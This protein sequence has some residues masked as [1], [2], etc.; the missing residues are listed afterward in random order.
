MHIDEILFY[1]PDEELCQEREKLFTEKFEF[2]KEPEDL[3]SSKLYIKNY[4]N[5]STKY[6]I[7]V[8]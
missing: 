2:L 1:S 5:E 3:I 4:N 7:L 8:T 6:N